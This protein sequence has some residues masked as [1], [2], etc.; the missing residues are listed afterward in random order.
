MEAEGLCKGSAL[1]QSLGANNNEG[2]AKDS[3]NNVRMSRLSKKSSPSLPVGVPGGV[4]GWVQRDLH[5]VDVV[6]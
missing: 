5:Y 6:C 4:V 3:S 2:S 1:W